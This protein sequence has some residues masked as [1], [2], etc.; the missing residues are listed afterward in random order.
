[1][2]LR[3]T[4][5]TGTRADFGL[6]TP[7]LEE[8]ERRVPAVEVGLLVMAMHL[9]A[10]FGSTI[11][12]VRRSG[13]RIVGEVPSVAES[14]APSAMAA[15]LGVALQGVAPILAANRPDW[16]LV[17]GDRG[18]QLAAALAALHEGIAVAHLH[19]GERTL[20]AVDDVLRDLI[21]RIAHLHLVA[22]TDAEGRL[23]DL[24]I[25]HWRI[26]RTGAPGLDAIVS[27]VTA[28]DHFV[29]ARYGLPA[30]GP[31]LMVVV[32]PE[33]GAAATPG[34]ELADS[35]LAALATIDVPAVGI[36]PNADSGGRA[37]AERFERMRPRFASLHASLPHN[38]Y[39]ALLRGAAALVGN[40]SS[41]IIEAPFLGVPVVNVG[42]RQMGRERGDNVLDVDARPDAVAAGVARA[43]EPSFAAGLVGRS[44][45]GD[46]AAAPRI[47]DALLETPIDD[48]LLQRE[49]S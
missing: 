48:R 2:T 32:H 5:V 49:L 28:D 22:T 30:E 38:D 40:S 11:E 39:L 13:V 25:E 16:L 6:W 7:V 15:G 24:G 10:R 46:G 36:W 34:K 31:Y 20:G 42:R 27:L 18:E 14:D 45:Y 12:E 41:G 9:D 21:S 33:T 8:L 26:R 47:V 17:L 43:I 19:G 4:V 1:M 3:V 44:P 23:R 37:I 29:R 35:V